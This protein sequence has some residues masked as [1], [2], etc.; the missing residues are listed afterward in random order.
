MDIAKNIADKIQA[1]ITPEEEER[2]NKIPTDNLIAYDYYLKGRDVMHNLNR[3]SW[4]E[5]ITYFEKAIEHDDEFAHAYANIAIAYYLLDFFKAEKIYAEQINNYSDKALSLDSKLPES[6]VAKAFYYM[7]NGETDMAISYLEKA[8]LYNPNSSVVINTLSDI[9]ANR[10]PNTEKYLEY[11]LK[12]IRLNIAAHDAINASYIYLHLGNAFIQSGFIDEAETYINKSLKYY[13]ENLFSQYVKAYILYAKNRDLLQIKDQLIE[14][15]R[16]DTTRMDVMQ[17]V[18]KIFYYMRDY[19]NAYKYYK[20][21]ID[22]KEAKNLEL[23]PAENSKIGFVLA[24]MGHKEESE[25]YFEKFREY[26]EYDT[27]IYKN[28]SWSMYYS[29]MGN[30]KK[31]LEHLKLF[32]QQ[33]NYFLWIFIF[34]EINPL[35]DNIKDNPEFKK[36]LKDIEDKFWIKHNQ[37]KVTLE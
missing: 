8:L 17:E 11:A 9:Y 26:V 22:I 25:K 30:T 29:Y 4:E 13:P 33:Y 12:G 27:S 21:F 5:A 37:I 18:G 31:S 14:V 15:F 35:A 1:V 23:F 24:Q 36:I 2:I 6:L 3:E 19:E 16:K 32:S 28:Y 7:H 20:K 10:R 34:L